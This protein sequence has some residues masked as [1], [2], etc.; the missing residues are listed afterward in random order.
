ME[1]LNINK[2]GENKFLVKLPSYNNYLVDGSVVSGNSRFVEVEDI[3]N[4]RI[5]TNN[6]I[7]CRYENSEGKIMSVKEY[8]KHT[9]DLIKE[10][11][12]ELSDSPEKDEMNFK[13]SQIKKYYKPIKRTIQELS[14]PIIVEIK[15]KVKYYKGNKYIE[16]T[17]INN[18]NDNFMY[19][20]NRLKFYLDTVEK[21][22]ENLKK[23]YNIT[24]KTKFDFRKNKIEF[25]KINGDYLF[26]SDGQQKSF[27]DCEPEK[28]LE[29]FENDKKQIKE[30]VKSVFHKKYKVYVSKIELLKLLNDGKIKEVKKIIENS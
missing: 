20:Y 30:M 19:T 4:I 16:N 27:R 7:I 28:L 1:I 22:Y 18:S 24:E 21:M 13:L 8:E 25:W 9:N 17:F 15:E 11:S 14:E 3:Y 2:L 29:K 10:I 12:L 6:T 26:S 23:E 5:V